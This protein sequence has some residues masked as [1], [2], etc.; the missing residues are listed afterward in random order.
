MLTVY[1]AVALIAGMFAGILLGEIA[2]LLTFYSQQLRRGFRAGLIQNRARLLHFGLLSGYT[3]MYLGFLFLLRAFAPESCFWAA[4]LGSLA[5]QGG[6][7]RQ[8]IIAQHVLQ[9]VDEISLEDAKANVAINGYM[10]LFSSYFQGK[11]PVLLRENGFV[12]PIGEM[13]KEM[14][15]AVLDRYLFLFKNGVLEMTCSP[16]MDPL[17]M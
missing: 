4:L 12:V 17:E 13:S 7:A 15:L 10:F 9:Q 14:A 2:S 11:T 6:P 8:R 16:Y 3:A 1:L 5:V